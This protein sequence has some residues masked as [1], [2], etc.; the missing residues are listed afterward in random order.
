M[1]GVLL[2]DPGEFGAMGAGATCC[3]ESNKVK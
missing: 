3:Y 1:G 2:N